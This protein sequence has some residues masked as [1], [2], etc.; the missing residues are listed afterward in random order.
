M[1]P[2]KISINHYMRKF[3]LFFLLYF[4]CLLFAQSDDPDFVEANV[5]NDTL[6]FQLKHIEVVGF[7]EQ[8]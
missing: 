1:P 2:L 6:R 7:F 5:D 4:S 8:H 3:N